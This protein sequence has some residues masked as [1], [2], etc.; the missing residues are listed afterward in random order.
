MSP[1]SYQLLHPASTLTAFIIHNLSGRV[2][3]DC[4]KKGGGNIWGILRAD[5]GLGGFSAFRRS[6][7]SPLPQGQRSPSASPP[8]VFSPLFPHPGI[9]FR[10]LRGLFLSR[11]APV[12]AVPDRLQGPGDVVQGDEN[13]SEHGKGDDLAGHN[14]DKTQQQGIPP[15]E[16]IAEAHIIFLSLWK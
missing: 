5:R 3:G 2:K 13:Q 11:S 15:K 4:D 10:R 12:Q 8:A 9:A 7:R 16:R 6:L 1:T 14:G